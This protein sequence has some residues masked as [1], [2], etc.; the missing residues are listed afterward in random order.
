[1]HDGSAQPTEVTP[2]SLWRQLAWW[3]LVL[4]A[5]MAYAMVV[6]SVYWLDFSHVMAGTLWTGTDI[7]MGFFLG[8]ILRRLTPPQRKAVIQW[9]V[10]RTILYLPVLAAT[11]GTAGWTLAGWLHLFTP[12]NPLR[13]W[14]L[15]ALVVITILSLQGFGILLPT[16]IRT[17][18]ELQKLSPDLDRVYRLNRRN[19]SLAGFQGILQ[20]LIILIMAHLATGG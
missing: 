13:S 20:V 5:V 2:V 19:N 14:V 12:G 6:H 18:L 11:T 10:P 8:P 1:M 15:A 9:L 7:F 16:S 4:P 17:Y 3:V